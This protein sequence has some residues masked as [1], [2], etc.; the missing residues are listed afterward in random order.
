LAWEQARTLV[1][2][3]R[4]KAEA[5][6]Y[7]NALDRDAELRHAVPDHRIVDPRLGLI[8][9]VLEKLLGLL[10]R[11]GSDAATDHQQPGGAGL[12]L[13]VHARRQAELVQGIDGLV[14]G[15]NDVD[16]PLVRPDLELLPRLLVDVRAPEHRVPLDPGRQGNRTV[17]DDGALS[18]CAW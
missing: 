11:P 16:Q 4:S 8:V 9:A 5:A 12:D 17:D 1:G 14:R 15:L 10:E 3:S 7:S 6:E 13:D 2:C 18:R